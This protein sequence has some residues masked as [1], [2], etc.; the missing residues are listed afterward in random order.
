MNIDS[1][2]YFKNMFISFFDFS[3]NAKLHNIKK[4]LKKTQL[5]TSKLNKKLFINF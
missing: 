3:K 4:C 2:F 1:L 5:L